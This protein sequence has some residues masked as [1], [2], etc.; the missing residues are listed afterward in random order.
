MTTDLHTR[1]RAAEAAG[2]QA[3]GTTPA[4]EESR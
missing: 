1:L 3:L 2:R 4:I